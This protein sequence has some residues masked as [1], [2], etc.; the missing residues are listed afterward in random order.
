MKKTNK[1]LTKTLTDSWHRQ[2]F[3]KDLNPN[4][5]TFQDNYQL[6]F[7]NFS[8]LYKPYRST[9]VT[10]KPGK[11]RKNQKYSGMLLRCKERAN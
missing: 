7:K 4:S 5:R 11:P 1:T 10:V 2:G 8:T 3:F 9:G 6:K